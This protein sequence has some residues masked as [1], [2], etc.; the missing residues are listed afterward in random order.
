LSDA[1]SGAAGVRIVVS[2]NATPAGEA[3]LEA[4]VGL[5]AALN[6]EIA[7]LF[8]E[9]VGLMRMAALPFTRELGLTSALVRPI[10]TDDIERALR[11]EAEQ[12]RALLASAAAA[13]NLRWSFQVVRGHSV[14]AV[15]EF[16]E[17][18]TLVVLGPTS[19]GAASWRFRPSAP[20]PGTAASE[21]A[22]FRYLGIRPVVVVFD[23]TERGMRSLAAAHA[24]AARASAR[25]T[26]FIA[27][28]T[29][30]EFGQ[31][32]EHARSWLVTQGSTA[33]YT[34]LKG[35]DVDSIVRALGGENASAFVLHEDEA[36]ADRRVLGTLLAELGCPLV[37]VSRT[38]DAGG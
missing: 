9:D 32:R 18:C 6:A 7:G 10:E 16:G 3:A 5:A 14:N 13:L 26:V 15:F 23:G 8:V 4:A 12:T 21:R 28:D 19:G 30:E 17:G 1:E 27:A 20:L 35:R 24:L 11:L 29:A 33:R 22:G 37:L 34:W 36:P 31:R 25:I 2:F 38:R